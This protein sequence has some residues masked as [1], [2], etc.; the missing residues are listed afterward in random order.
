M[1]SQLYLIEGLGPISE[2]AAA[3]PKRLSKHV[4]NLLRVSDKVPATY[5]SIEAA[6][7]ARVDVTDMS[8]DAATKIANRGTKVEDGKIQWSADPRLRL[9]SQQRLTEEQVLAF[10]R[11]I[12]A[13]I[14][15][16]SATHGLKMQQELLDGRLKALAVPVDHRTVEGGHH[17]HMERPAE[18]ARLM[19][20]A[21]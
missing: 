10:L 21:T 2:E 18:I 20:S 8:L 19:L 16:V 5:P 7:R 13:P 6:A 12:T 1:C 4:G 14:T 3:L 9:D 11:A 17:V 15:L